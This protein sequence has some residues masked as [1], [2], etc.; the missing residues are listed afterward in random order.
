MAVPFQASDFTYL[1][2]WK[3]GCHLLSGSLLLLATYSDRSVRSEEAARI[4]SETL[5]FLV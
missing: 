1:V 3:S 5:A 2:S 4:T